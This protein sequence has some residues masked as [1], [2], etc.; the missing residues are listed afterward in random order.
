MTVGRTKAMALVGLRGV[1]VDVEADIASGL[2]K[3]SLVGL[4]DRALAEATDRVR[5]A[6]M[7]SNVPMPS[8]RVTVN[9]SPAS[10]PKAGSGFDLAIALASLAAA[11]AVPTESVAASAH[12]GELALDG[13][14]RPTP[15]VLPGVLG[16]ARAGVRTVLVP[17]ANEFEA[18]LVPDIEV[19]PVAS[20]AHALAWH[21]AEVTPADIDPLLLSV[22][23]GDDEPQ[24]DLA[25][26]V[27]QRD[28][29][30]TLVIAAAGGHHMFMLGPPGSGKTMLASRL[31][32]IL[33]DLSV[34]EALDVASARSLV[35]GASVRELSLRP[36]YE[37]PHHSATMAALVGGGSGL[38]RPGAVARASHGVLFLDEA[39][40]FQRATLDA[41]RQPLESGNIVIQRA[42]MSTTFPARFQLVLAANPCPCGKYGLPGNECSC[43]PFARRRYLE[44]ISGPLRDRIDINLNV[45][46]VGASELIDAGAPALTSAEVRRRVSAARAS[47]RERWRDEGWLTNA[48]VPGSALRS[49]RWRLPREAT[50]DVDYAVNSGHLT[51]RGYDRTIRLAW[52]L[53]DLESHERPSRDHVGR[54]YLLRK[55]AAP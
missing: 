19:V 34:P 52:T 51:M 25:D 39:P 7:N 6:I 16:A 29:I 48:A 33:P 47:A 15:G 11:G 46:R 27:G 55:G 5:S 54:A 22:S 45:A 53:A 41:L 4:P 28:A 20:L 42:A 31:P 9:L 17:V 26:V 13:R 14:L 49:T 10:L 38:I 35:P 21:G 2:P 44:R 50:G 36:P 8:Q 24:P 37:A 3:F 43:A 12:I 40:E 30:D 32:G 1:T 18:R 23:Q